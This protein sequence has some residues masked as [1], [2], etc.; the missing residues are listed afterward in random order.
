MS[1]PQIPTVVLVH[2]AWHGAWC[3][4]ALQGELDARDIASFAID[5]PGHGASLDDFGDLVGNAD[6]VARVLAK[7]DRR[8][9]LVGHSYG[10]A[11]ITQAASPSADVSHLI[12][13]SAFVPDVGETVIG[14]SQSLPDAPTKL[15]GAMVIGTNGCSTIN[16]ELAHDAFYGHGDPTSSAA[17]VA[18]LC[19][20]PFATFTQP[21]SNAAWRHIPSTFVRCTDD[22]AVHITLQDHMAARCTFTATIDT[23]HSPFASAPTET[24]DIIERIARG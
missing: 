9:V 24:A 17:H 1:T 16:P 12:Y 13:I 4:A 23:D 20:Q 11:V 5:L 14:L 18:R 10:G 6:H 15:S 8:V 22:Q 21:L 3:W 7:L 19:A 2:G